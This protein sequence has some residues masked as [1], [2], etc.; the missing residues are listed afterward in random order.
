MNYRIQI[1]KDRTQV[2]HVNRLKLCPV[3]KDIVT[4]K[5]TIKTAEELLEQFSDAETVEIRYSDPEGDEEETNPITRREQESRPPRQKPATRDDEWASEDEIPLS[6][7]QK[8]TTK[9]ESDTDEED[10]IP[11]VV[12]K[13]RL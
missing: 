11:L 13:E 1:S 4:G 2:V 7:L 6:E 9:K 8:W 12:L 10:D 3:G 5:Y